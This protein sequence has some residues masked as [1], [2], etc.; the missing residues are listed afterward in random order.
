MPYACWIVRSWAASGVAAR[1]A[2]SSAKYSS[3]PPGV[4]ISSAVAGLPTSYRGTC[5]NVKIPGIKEF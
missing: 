4:T 1:A 5:N 2:N 3:N